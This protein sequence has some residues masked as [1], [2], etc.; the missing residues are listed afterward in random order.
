[1]KTETEKEIHINLHEVKNNF[2]TSG[3]HLFDYISNYEFSRTVSF[4]ERVTIYCQMISIFED[5]F[6]V[7]ENFKRQDQIEYALVYPK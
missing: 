7:L 1:M 2:A 5:E 4:A 3:K 6:E